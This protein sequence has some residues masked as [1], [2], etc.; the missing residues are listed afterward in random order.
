MS[1]PL[2]YL[3]VGLAISLLAT[4]GPRTAFADSEAFLKLSGI[5][6]GSADPAHRGESDVLSVGY[7]VAR[8]LLTQA[9][10]SIP[11]GTQAKFSTLSLTK[12]LDSAS[13]LLFISSALGTRIP[14]AT[15]T[16]RQAGGSKPEYLVIKL[17][18]V[19]ITGFSTGSSDVDSGDLIETVSL[20]FQMIEVRYQRIAS[21]GTP[22][23]PLVDGSWNL[24]ANR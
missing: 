18:G 8:P 5:A 10:S 19:L 15:I 13:P 11:S 1:H 7:S 6:G 16:L 21:D 24:R 3:L 2:R 22:Q 17:V 20:S 4:L 9:G 12:R 23:G 14:D